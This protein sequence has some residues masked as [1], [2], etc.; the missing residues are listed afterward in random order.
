MMVIPVEDFP[1]ETLQLIGALALEH[2]S[3][4]DSLTFFL[5]VYHS[6]HF[7]LGYALFAEL[8]FGRKVDLLR[9]ALFHARSGP[10]DPEGLPDSE[11]A[12][13]L[14]YLSELKAL[15]QRRN[16]IM[17]GAVCWAGIARRHCASAPTK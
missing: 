11:Y 13:L 17:H 9:E 14:K 12:E 8:F 2:S 16:D 4:D 3:A 10:A 7:T 6:R 5:T 1:P 15:G